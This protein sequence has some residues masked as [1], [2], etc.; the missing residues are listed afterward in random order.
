METKNLQQSHKMKLSFI[1]IFISMWYLNTIS[2]QTQI[3]VYPGFVSGSPIANGS[4][5]TVTDALFGAAGWEAAQNIDF[6]LSVENRIILEVDETA[7]V[8]K[9]AAFTATVPIIVEY[10]DV[11]GTPLTPQNITLSLNNWNQDTKTTTPHKA[12]HY[13]LWKNGNTP[14]ARY[15]KMRI[16]VQ[17]VTL[18]GAPNPPLVLK[19]E[20]IVHRKHTFNF[21]GTP[22]I[23]TAGNTAATDYGALNWQSYTGADEYDLEWVFYDDRS[24][25]GTKINNGVALTTSE[26]NSLFTNNS[27][28]VTVSNQNFSIPLLYPK[29]FLFYRLR[30]ARYDQNGVRRFTPWTASSTNARFNLAGHEDL[31]WQVQTTFAEEGKYVP[32]LEYFDGTLRSRQTLS[33]SNSIGSTL[34]SSTI[35]DHNGRPAVQTLTA[36]TFSNLFRYDAYFAAKNVSGVL[37]PYTKADFDLGNC[38][39]LPA[40]MGSTSSG[41]GVER[42]FSSNNPQ[43]TNASARDKNVPTAYGYPFF[44]TEYTADRTGRIRRQRMPGSIFFAT[45]NPDYSTR[46]L[47]GK[48]GQNELDRLFGNDVGLA[49][50]Y[51]KNL[52]VDGNNQASVSYV[53]MNGR[54]IATAL[55]GA[56]PAILESSLSTSAVTS[57]KQDLLNN[58]I[59]DNK[60]IST[61][62][63]LVPTAGTYS[64]KYIINAATYSPSC[65]SFACYDCRYDITIKITDQCGNV[66]F[67]PTTIHNYRPTSVLDQACLPTATFYNVDTTAS[68]TLNPGEYTVTKTITL[69][70]STVDQNLSFFLS[71]TTC[72]PSLQALKTQYQA[73]LDLSSCLTTCATCNT[74]LQSLE[75]LKNNGVITQGEYNQAKKDCDELCATSTNTCEALKKTLEADVTPGGQYALYSIDANGNLVPGDQSSIFNTNKFQTLAA[76][77]YVNANGQQDFILIE[78]QSLS[79]NQLTPAQFLTHWKSSW[80]PA[81]AKLHPEYCFYQWCSGQTAVNDFEKDLLNI[82]KYSDAVTK[83]W[84]TGS[85]F[86]VLNNDPFFNASGL[87]T[88][89]KTQLQNQIDN[90]AG[91]GV[92][93]I[94]FASD[95]VFGVACSTLVGQG[96]TSTADNDAAWRIIRNIY[97]GLASNCKNQQ[98][99]T[100]PNCNSTIVNCIGNPNCVDVNYKFKVRRA[101]NNTTP[102]NYPTAPTATDLNNQEATATQNL[103]T[104][105]QQA[106]ADNVDQWLNDLTGP[107][108][109]T[110][111]EKTALR[112]RLLAVCQ[113]SC[114]ESHPYGATSTPPGAKTTT[115]NDV[116]FEQILNDYLGTTRHGVCKPCFAGI[117]TYPG[118][119]LVQAYAGART[120]DNR[121]NTCAC[122]NL[123]KL[124]AQYTSNP[125][126]ATSFANY[127]QKFSPTT[128]TADDISVL[129]AVCTTTVRSLSDP[130][131]LP[132]YLECGVCKPCAEMQS[133]VSAYTSSPN[134]C[135][136]N[137][138][139]Y[140]EYLGRYLNYRL[141]WNLSAD[142]YQNFLEGC[143]STPLPGEMPILHRLL[144]PNEP[145]VTE[146][147][148][149]DCAKSLQAQ[150]DQQ[151]E[152][153]Y[154]VQLDS[155]KTKF[156]NEYFD[157][158]LRN[159]SNEQLFVTSN[160]QEYQYTL[161]YYDQSGQLTQTIPPAGVTLLTDAEVTSVQNARLV[162]TGQV[163]PAHTLTTRYAYTSL[164]GQIS[165]K[166]PDAEEVHNWYDAQGRLVV[167][168][169]GRQRALQRL[170]YTMYDELGRVIEV[171]EVQPINIATFLTKTS[172]IVQTD[173]D[174]LLS[175]GNRTQVTR[176]YFDTSPISAPDGLTQKNLRSR[177]AMQ[178]IEATYDGN[179]T[180][181]D[182]ATHYD[183]DL[184]GDVSTII[185]ELQPLQSVG[186][187]YKRIVYDYDQLSGKVN[188]VHYQ[189]GRADQYSTHYR[190]DLDNRLTEVYTSF[191]DSLYTSSGKMLWDVQAAYTYY[192]HGPLARTELG[193]LRVQGLDYAYTL[194][195][196]IKGLNSS[197]LDPTRDIGR[198]GI[199]GT[200]S[201]VSRDVFSYTLGFYINGVQGDY[202]PINSSYAIEPTYSVGSSFN[203]FSKSMYN[204]NIRYIMQQNQGTSSGA[205]IHGYSYDQVMRLKQMNTYVPSNPWVIDLS[206][207]PA[208]LAANFKEL[209]IIYDRNG[210]IKNYQ[211]WGSSTSLIQDDLTYDYYPN[212]NRLRKVTDASTSSLP[213]EVLT[214]SDAN[215]YDYDAS[216]N[217]KKDVQSGIADG[218]ITWNP[219]GKILSVTRTG[220]I[221]NTF[222]YDAMQNRVRKRRYDPTK[223]PIADTTTYYIRDAQ[224]NALAVYDQYGSTVAWREQHIYGSS[225]LGTVQPGVS[226][227]STP[228]T[229]PNF[230]ANKLLNL[231]WHRYEVT[232]HL[233]NVRS[234]IN[235]RRSITNPGLSTQYY[236][237][238]I[239]NAT[240]YFP[241]GAEMRNSIAALA[242]NKQY[243][244]GFNGKELDKNG[245][246]GSLNHYDYG[247][248]IY[249]PGIGRFLSVDPLTRSYPWYTPY[250]FAGNS[251]I[252]NV[253]LDGLEELHFSALRFGN[254][255]LVKKSTIR[256]TEPIYM[257]TLFGDIKIG[258]IPLSKV[259]VL[260]IGAEEYF[261]EN[262]SDLFKAAGT[263]DWDYFEESHEVRGELIDI[264]ISRTEVI[265]Y[266]EEYIKLAG[267]LDPSTFSG[268]NGSPSTQLGFFSW[269]F[270]RKKGS[271]YVVP[272][273]ATSSGRPY[274]GRHNKP[275]PQK[276]RK[277]KDGRDREKAKVIKR[278]DENDEEL[279]SYLEQKEIDKRGGLDKLDN[280][281]REMNPERYKTAEK[282]YKPW[283]KFW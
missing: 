54:T 247:F 192:R 112:P 227:T 23:T 256:N 203:T 33:L 22:T 155:V 39:A 283:W 280:K 270:K 153:A 19:G 62:T 259:Y 86:N 35:Y 174:A 132:S 188:Y 122:G 131:T 146:E 187:R 48:P 217:L 50:H 16:T 248:R 154:R 183:Y 38:S 179:N 207:N 37:Q 216:G 181:Y 51:Q 20:I 101:P 2:A 110:D 190:Y 47:Y 95:Q 211:R 18:T 180:T 245:E 53:D 161:Y 204:G 152:I 120:V 77:E 206:S 253:D 262:F 275:K 196:W 88:T 260:D 30:A 91:T 56:S 199:G 125:S 251:P 31:N 93:L 218:S 109:L 127:L 69:N 202:Q 186:H 55:A 254:G 191:V 225:R 215:N 73:A 118:T 81:L 164:N 268:G 264:A 43:S 26:I 40:A 83:G 42:Y 87:G 103:I 99:A 135:P 5:F 232:D 12:Y 236:S 76:T 255:S 239:L 94:K 67:N 277:S 274:V 172:P 140:Y 92:S 66:V 139:D 219:Y 209:G 243:R 143:S 89:C 111:P 263:I 46:Y 78:G 85:T 21:S 34:K 134:S 194:Q 121:D 175:G 107:C 36:P 148:P 222:G 177:V 230:R 281:R 100:A 104:E 8:N 198:D 29:G 28:R 184:T 70:Q 136:N 106:C 7:T 221:Q 273:K 90:F 242:G 75:V 249:N 167:S 119:Y 269:L 105:C 84:M 149:N 171:G 45:S 193:A 200:T 4:T 6:T 128:F 182:Y 79:P 3:L 208:P 166:S 238:T 151:A 213:G 157:V 41:G 63:L 265:E 271:I 44:L 147:L 224:G 52:V 261:F 195:G 241:F 116:S 176:T 14:T 170:S 82:E 133:L 276:T 257:K 15:H 173:I 266:V 278:Y 234:I 258:D 226:W 240:D 65:A 244:Y 71:Q 25:I 282:K 13:Y 252:A 168:Q 108:V 210:N 68:I 130:I 11:N 80:A 141:G 272:G 142:E 250:Q 169:D 58:I 158:C 96:G 279:G 235:D 24:V 160:F 220:G 228:P 113:L 123:S 97:L 64:L 10:W 9:N 129:E 138:P 150:A 102:A 197:F 229:T 185:Q 117:I 49:S 72:I 32:S 214:Q 212:T 115:Y 205:Y 237:A 165:H 201:L 57:F 17:N 223:N 178:S 267:S 162:G 156:L 189:R 163:Y 246:F 61:G 233:G 1:L 60:N 231:G 98:R 114:D 159:M 59:S 145:F 124:K 27:T 126:G 137:V 144:C 74:K